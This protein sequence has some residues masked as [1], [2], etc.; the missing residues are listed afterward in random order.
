MAANGDIAA[1]AGLPV[2]PAV[3][4]A[5]MGYDEI[6]LTRDWI[7]KYTPPGLIG[8]AVGPPSTLDV[9]SAFVSLA[10]IQV[11][12]VAGRKYMVSGGSTGLRITSPGY[13]ILVLRAGG[14]E[15]KRLLG[16]TATPVA[17]NTPVTGFGRKVYTATAT[18]SLTF[19]IA[20]A[21]QTPGALRVS[22]N[23]ANII[24]EDLG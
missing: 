8:E 9:V 5:Q 19:D 7:V 1:G 14:G 11:A 22:G 17:P 13:A 24:V 6:N 21:G 10:S 12:I 16:E 15:I 4:P 2:V 20:A 3:A 23:A 18:T